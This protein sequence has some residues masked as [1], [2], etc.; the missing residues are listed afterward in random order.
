[1][2][3]SSYVIGAT[4]NEYLDTGALALI[5]LTVAA[6]AGHGLIRLVVGLARRG[7]RS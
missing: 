4:R 5:A 2:L 7:R 3:G 1:M 6:L